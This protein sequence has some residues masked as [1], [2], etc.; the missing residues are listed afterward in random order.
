MS[1]N[2][3]WEN[4]GKSALQ[5]SA[6]NLLKSNFIKSMFLHFVLG[7]KIN[8]PKVAMNTTVMELR[9]IRMAATM[10]DN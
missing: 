8:V 7:L 5:K 1:K 6:F 10:G 2:R 3:P 4:E 9:G